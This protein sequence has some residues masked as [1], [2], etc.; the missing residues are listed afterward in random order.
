MPKRAVTG[1]EVTNRSSLLH[2]TLLG[3]LQEACRESCTCERVEDRQLAVVQ[4]EMPKRAVTGAE[5]FNRFPPLHSYLLRQLQ[6]AAQ[7]MQGP[8]Q[9]MHPS[10]YPILVLLSRLRHSTQSASNAE[11][12][13]CGVAIRTVPTAM[14]EAIRSA[15]RAGLVVVLEQHDWAG[16]TCLLGAIC[17]HSA[18]TLWVHMLSMSSPRAGGSV[19]CYHTMWCCTSARQALRCSI[20][21]GCSTGLTHHLALSCRRTSC[22]QLSL[23]QW[24]GSL[25]L[26]GPWRCAT[27]LPRLWSPWSHPGSSAL[28]CVTS[29]RT[30]LPPLQLSA[31][32]R[33][34]I[35]LAPCQSHLA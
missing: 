10:L 35:S 30:Y 15:W 21:Q 17:S 19:R 1:A 31:T 13:C 28:C 29:C 32:T 8:T 12:G 7:G 6:E 24:C 16:L 34:V 27:W 23:L 33:C 14:S 25:R 18:A 26:P 4:G 20:F 3:Q 5:F 11:V 22:R 2:S 9:R